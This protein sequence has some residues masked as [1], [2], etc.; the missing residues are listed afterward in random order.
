[1]TFEGPS[2]TSV[3]ADSVGHYEADLPFGV[4][5]ATATFSSSSEI[6]SHPRVF[7][8]T[9]P[10]NVAIDLYLNAIGCGGVKLITPDGRPP[11]LKEVERKNEGCQAEHYSLCPQMMACHSSSWS[12][13]CRQPC[14]H[15]YVKTKQHVSDNLPPTTC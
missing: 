4:W 15:R 13:A 5:T 3:K 11:T 10:T 12:A 7:R 6:L 2:K 8:A 9:A 14:V 1:V